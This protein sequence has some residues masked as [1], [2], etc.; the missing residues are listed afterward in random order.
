MKTL[1]QYLR[2]HLDDDVIDHS[3]R[4]IRAPGG[5]VDFYIHAVGVDGE[6]CDFTVRG[7][8]VI[9]LDGSGAGSREPSKVSISLNGESVDLARQGPIPRIVT[10]EEI[11][12]LSGFTEP[13]TPTVTYRRAGALGDSVGILAPGQVVEVVDGSIVECVDTGNA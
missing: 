4:A 13:M 1:E 9:G 8:V 5:T 2:D 10:Y 7:N 3:I 6:T 11:V 12:A